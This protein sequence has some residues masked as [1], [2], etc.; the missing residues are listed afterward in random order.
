VHRAQNKGIRGVE[1]W[2]NSFLISARDR[3]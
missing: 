3:G 2:F 1:V